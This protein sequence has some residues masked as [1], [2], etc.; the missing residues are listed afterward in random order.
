MSKAIDSYFYLI[1]SVRFKVSGYPSH[2]FQSL[3]HLWCAR[4]GDAWV[5][6]VGMLHLHNPKVCIT[7]TAI[8]SLSR[9]IISSSIKQ[10]PKKLS[11]ILAVEFIRN[12][13]IC[14]IVTSSTVKT[15]HTTYFILWRISCLILYTIKNVASI[16]QYIQDVF[17]SMLKCEHFIHQLFVY[18]LVKSA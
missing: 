2:R 4:R 5:V 14:N 12:V 13:E 10:R 15:N 9:N 1:Y 3:L 17:G 11:K 6:V 7:T 8:I 16:F 18:S